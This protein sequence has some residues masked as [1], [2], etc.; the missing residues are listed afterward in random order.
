MSDKQMPRSGSHRVGDVPHHL[1][2]G[3]GLQLLDPIA[4][5]LG[6]SSHCSSG[7]CLSAGLSSLQ[8]MR[9]DGHSPSGSIL[10]K[11]GAAQLAQQDLCPIPPGDVLK[12][13]NLAADRSTAPL[14]GVHN[15]WQLDLLTPTVSIN[16]W[17]HRG[18]YEF[19]A[20]GQSAPVR[21]WCQSSWGTHGPS[22]PAVGAPRL[23]RRSDQAP[24]HGTPESLQRL[25]QQAHLHTPIGTISIGR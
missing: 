19:C 11:H 18:C 14:L 13:L 17:L 6:S 23:L 9:L 2:W 16:T 7:S 4:A 22:W 8:C 20:R 12:A 25:A 10:H 1:G 3:V 21:G 5:S 15:S 24:P